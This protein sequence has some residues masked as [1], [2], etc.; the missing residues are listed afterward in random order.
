MST[1]L[2]TR[3][4]RL[5]PVAA[6]VVGAVIVAGLAVSFVAESRVGGLVCVVALA[7]YAGWIGMSQSRYELTGTALVFHSALG[8]TTLDRNQVRNVVW[9]RDEMNIEELTIRG[10][11][12]R[13]ISISKSDLEAN[14]QFERELAAFLASAP[15]TAAPASTRSNR[16]GSADTVL[17][18]AG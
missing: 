15:M 6:R 3:G 5:A 18:L 12:G 2:H 9:E 10:E 13:A 8:S 17:S 14:Q 16:S 1:T 11:L 4:H 7:V